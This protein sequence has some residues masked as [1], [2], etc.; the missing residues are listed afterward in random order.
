MSTLDTELTLVRGTA[1]D[2]KLTLVDQFGNTEDLQT[3]TDGRVAFVEEIGQTPVLLSKTI[4]AGDIEGA[5]VKGVVQF[6][7]TGADTALLLPSNVLGTLELD[8]PGGGGEVKHTERF[9]VKVLP[10]VI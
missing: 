5:G 3:F 10:K 8:V 2:V 1:A 7:L 4:T 9:L 6:S